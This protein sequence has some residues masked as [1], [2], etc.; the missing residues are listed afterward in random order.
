VPESQIIEALWEE[1]E[2][3]IAEKQATRG[4]EVQD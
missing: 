4:P 1:V 3:F 2:R